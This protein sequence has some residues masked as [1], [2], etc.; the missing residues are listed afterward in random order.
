MKNTNVEK[1]FL[2]ALPKLEG[3]PLSQC[4]FFLSNYYLEI[5]ND[6]FF[7]SEKYPSQRDRAQAMFPG[8]SEKA[9]DLMEYKFLSHRATDHGE[10]ENAERILVLEEDIQQTEYAEY[11]AASWWQN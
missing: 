1:F 10:E 9:L 3:V 8:M 6:R 5:E 11:A 7:P 4:A 2:E